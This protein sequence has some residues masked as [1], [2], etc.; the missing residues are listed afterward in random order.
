MASEKVAGRCLCGRVC[1]EAELPP[2]FV[3]HCHCENC[4]R[5]HG[6]GVVTWAGFSAGDFRIV[7]GEE[8]LSRYRTETDATR[9]FCAT[10][11]TTL[12]FESPRWEGEVHV[13][14]ASLL[15]PLGREPTGHA[16][17]DRAPAWCP[18][19]DELPRYGGESGTEPLDEEGGSE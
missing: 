4:R 2:R 5:A 14:V 1:F 19:L 8:R 6:A 3:A 17:A 18:I 10:C 9:S 12:L 16:Y 15:D 13:T 11:G 7:A